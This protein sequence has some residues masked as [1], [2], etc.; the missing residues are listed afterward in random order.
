MR[1]LRRFLPIAVLIIFG[2]SFGCATAEP[3][4][5]AAAPSELKAAAPEFREVQVGFFTDQFFRK[6]HGGN[7]CAVVQRIITDS[8]RVLKQFKIRLMAVFCQSYLTDFDKI[9]QYTLAEKD[10]AGKKIYLAFLTAYF[11]NS[12]KEIYRAEHFA[13]LTEVAL[14]ENKSGNYSYEGRTMIINHTKYEV[15]LRIFLHEFGHAAGC[16]LHPSKPENN[17]M[18]NISADAPL[19]YGPVYE[20][21]LRNYFQNKS[22]A[23]I[24]ELC[25]RLLPR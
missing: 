13:L 12:I 24:L 4:P 8:N 15:V 23:E 1:E 21:I 20:E 3:K 5:E 14:V 22:P 11:K 10:R 17:L 7:S 9:F 2:F 18:N 19:I 25:N 16:D 6:V